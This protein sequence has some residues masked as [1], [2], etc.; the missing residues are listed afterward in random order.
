MRRVDP[1]RLSTW[2]LMGVALALA[3]AW[4]WRCLCLFPAHGWNE[5][6]LA[7][8]F[9]W[10]HG[11]SPYPPAG[12][13]PATTWIYGP[14]PL[15]L[16]LPATLAHDAASAL[17]VAGSINLAVVL[18]AIAAVCAWWPA[19]FTALAGP[20][21]LLAFVACVTLWPA[22]SLEFMQPD[23]AAV[24]FG[25][26]AL[27][28]LKKSESTGARWLAAAS[29]AAAIAC[30]QTLLG[31]AL[32]ECVYLAW[33][34][35]LRAGVEQ[36]LRIVLL[37]FAVLGGA[38]IIFGPAGFVFHLLTL[39]AGLP[40]AASLSARLLEFTPYL[41]FQAGVPLILFGLLGARVWKKDSPWLLPALAWACAW[42]LDLVAL[43]KTGGSINSLHGWLF[44]LPPAATLLAASA[45]PTG[46]W[47]PAVIVLAAA[48]LVARLATGAPGTWRPLDQHLRQGEF[49]ARSLPGEVY[50][51]WH[52]LVTFYAE[53]RFDHV[54]DGLFML[55]LAG[56]PVAGAAATAHLPPRMHVVALLHHE[57]DWGIA[58]FLIPPG[59]QVSAFGAWDLSSWPTSKP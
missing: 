49:L 57:I 30:K 6:R 16:Q 14:L 42:P 33:R 38:A 8:S 58:R 7:P 43:F 59:A 41:L 10:A 48:G 47:R 2:F 11:V 46:A 9:M 37:V 28:C 51:P 56:Q 53:G 54:E 50:F 4:L 29:C 44:F 17:L 15:L 55:Y 5:I 12:S 45:R 1:V 39:P 13:G 52:P 18:L 36:G 20:S 27:L 35:G 32:A 3:G 25:L 24:A 26:L 34:V 22:T 21:R 23:N 31:L 40:W 19:P